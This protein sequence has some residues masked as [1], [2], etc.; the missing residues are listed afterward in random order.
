[1]LERAKCK[2]KEEGPEQSILVN[3]QYHTVH[4]LEHSERDRTEKTK[5]KRRRAHLPLMAALL[6]F[7]SVTYD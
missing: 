6:T 2:I 1:M 5:N 4:I 3:I 7:P